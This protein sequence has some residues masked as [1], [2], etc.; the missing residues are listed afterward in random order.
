MQDELK[1]EDE[2]VLSLSRSFLLKAFRRIVPNSPCLG[3]GGGVLAGP[4]ANIQ[5]VY[6][7]IYIIC[8]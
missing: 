8:K 2:C 7:C 6:V 3:W 5:Y 4:G 1:P